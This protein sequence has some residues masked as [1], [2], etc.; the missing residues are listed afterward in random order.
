MY[1]YA[2]N[3]TITEVDKT[4]NA[5][6]GSDLT[7]PTLQDVEPAAGIRVRR[8]LDGYSSSIYY[9]LFLPSDWVETGGK[10][11]CVFDLAGNQFAPYSGLPSDA[12]FGYGL[13]GAQYVCVNVPFLNSLG[14][15]MNT[16]WWSNGDWTAD[17][18]PTVTYWLAVIQDLI[19]NFNVNKN[20]IVLTGFS[21]GAV[22]CHAVGCF[23]DNIAA[24]WKAF[25][26]HAH[27]DA[28]TYETAGS[29]ERLTRTNG[30]E[31]Y[32]TVGADDT[33]TA[34]ANSTAGYNFLDGL[35]Y[36][37][38]LTLITGFGHDPTWTLSGS[39]AQTVA[40]RTW[41]FNL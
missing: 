23:T 29:E 41:L 36:P 40:A 7:L 8:R 16:T 11:R 31:T 26:P 9:S 20:H 10:W 6:L 25:V 39:A 2:L 24:K 21:R 28:G 32:V 27:M 30:R 37:T 3:N 14:T 5:T 33:A 38:T 22:A 4:Y 15:A 13:C 34:I 35:G 19:D 1:Y 18:T 17:P 12:P